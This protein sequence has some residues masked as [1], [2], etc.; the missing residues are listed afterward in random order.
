MLRILRRAVVVREDTPSLRTCG[1]GCWPVQRAS[2]LAGSAHRLA[3]RRA[4][5]RMP[6][7]P[8]QLCAI[9][10]SQ[11]LLGP[12]MRGVVC[13][14]TATGQTGGS[15]SC[16]EQ[17]KTEEGGGGLESGGAHALNFFSRA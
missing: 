8:E 4:A 13:M 16:A 3:A 15:W 9:T 11:T 1:L 5:G 12:M 6:E 2:G 7:Q 14:W 10:E 17:A